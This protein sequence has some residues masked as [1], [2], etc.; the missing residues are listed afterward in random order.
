MGTIK[1]LIESGFKNESISPFWIDEFFEEN[2]E[3]EIC[4]NACEK[5]VKKGKTDEK[6][7]AAMMQAGFSY[8]MIKLVLEK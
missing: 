5:L 4:K 8:K 6:L 1:L 7:I 3:M 2:D